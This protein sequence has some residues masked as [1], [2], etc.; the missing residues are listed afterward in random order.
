MEAITHNPTSPKKDPEPPQWKL[1]MPSIFRL[2]LK[3]QIYEYSNESIELAEF[4][5]CPF[6]ELSL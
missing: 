2:P 4:Q 1:L 5:Q 3:S 6:D